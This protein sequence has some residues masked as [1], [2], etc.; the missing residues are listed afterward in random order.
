M[1]RMT[2]TLIFL[3][4]L[5]F[6]IAAQSLYIHKTNGE[7]IIVPLN[8]IEKITFTDGG[9]NTISDVDGNV[10][11]IVLI[12]KQWW[13]AENLRTTKF[14]D[15]TPIPLKTANAD[16]LKSSQD[17]LPSYSWYDNNISN[18][19]TYGALYNW[20]VIDASSNGGKNVCPDGW[21]VPTDEDWTTLTNQLGGLNVAGGNL[22]DTGTSYWKEPNTGANNQSGFTGLPGGAR[23][24]AVFSEIKSVGRWWSSTKNDP[25]SSAWYRQVSSNSNSV[26][27]HHLGAGNGFSIRCIKE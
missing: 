7:V 22:K 8:S 20:Y 17:G 13:M 5:A 14:N 24:N 15:R 10:Y 25:F 1:K 12:G 3:W 4:S 27:R 18:K 26:L 2:F 16:W 9:A 21:K 6:T 23:V 11:K 19:G